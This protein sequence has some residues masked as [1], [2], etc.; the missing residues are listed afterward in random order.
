MADTSIIPAALA[1]PSG[2][3]TRELDAR[4]LE[5]SA[6]AGVTG[7]EDGVN[8]LQDVVFRLDV[9][10]RC[11]YI[12]PS[13]EQHSGLN[14]KNF[15]GKTVFEFGNGAQT[16]DAWGLAL[17]C[18]QALMSRRTVQREFCIRGRE[19]QTRLIP[20]MAEDGTV[21]SLLGISRDVTSLKRTERALKETQEQYRSL[22]ESIDGIV[23]EL[24]Y[25]TWRFTFVSRQ[26][27]RLLGYPV[28]RWL[29]EPTFW[30]DHVHAEDRDA[31]I[32]KCTR[33]SGRNENHELEYRM[34][35]ADGQIVWLR[36]IVTVEQ[37]EGRPFRLRGVMVDIT[38]VKN[39]EAERAGQNRI[40]EMIA[41]GAPLVEVLDEIVLLIESHC[42]GARCSVL[43]LEED[44]I[45]IG[46][47]V[48]AN[49]SEPLKSA[50]R[51]RKIGP[52]AGSCGT[53]MYLKRC[54][55]VQDTFTD[56]LWEDFRELAITQD[57]K[58]CWSTP[59]LTPQATVLGAFGMYYAESRAPNAAEQRLA[60]V[61]AR[62][63][64]IAIERD[65]AQESLRRSEAA[66][67]ESEERS[68]AT[69]RAIP[70]L[71]FLLSEEGT[72]LECHAQS[73]DQLVHERE[74]TIGTNIREALPGEIA[75]AYERAFR[76]ASKSDKAQTI[77]YDMVVRGERRH[78][79]TTIVRSGHGKFLAIVRNVSERKRA[80]AA[81]RESEE[82]FR[83]VAMA[84]RDAIYDVDLRRGIAW[85]NETYQ[86]L[87]S[88]DCPIPAEFGWWR[89]RIHPE[90]RERIVNEVHVAFLEGR[91]FWSDEYRFQRSNGTYANVMDRGYIFY[92]A[93][94]EVV[95]V[96]GA[97]TDVT[98][99]RE[100]E[101]ALRASEERYRN[102]VETQTELICRFLPDTTLTFVNDAYCRHFGKR[103]NELIGKSMLELVPEP[104]RTPLRQ[105]LFA[106][107]QGQ[108]VPPQESAMPQPDGTVR[109]TQWFNYALRDCEGKIELQGIARD[110]TE[111]KHAEQ[112]LRE[113]QE[114]LRRSHTQIR[115]LAG[116]LMNAQE[117][118]RR[119]LAREL[120][121][122]LN[123]QLAGLSILLSNTIR[124]LPSVEDYAAS[125]FVAYHLR[126]AMAAAR[127]IGD[128][129]RNLSHQLHPAT[130]EHAGISAAV[131]AI[132]K[133][134]ADA[135]P[136]DFQLI[137][138][139]GPIPLPDNVSICIYRIAQ[140]S[141]RNMVK[142]SGAHQAKVELGVHNRCLEFTVTDDGCGFDLDSARNKG[143]LGLISMFERIRLVQ[144][145]C[146]LKTFPGKGTSL[147]VTVPLR[148]E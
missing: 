122:D 102:V 140:E 131:R 8:E 19:Y 76:R 57:V 82:R 96:I 35:R 66:L 59:I 27:E 79:E 106:L 88:P 109:W 107:V 7:F 133:E 33:L 146:E 38:Q 54:V 37:C 95:R 60:E 70:D 78:R 24:D 86:R 124:E 148:S 75:D 42:A 9:D 56:P 118:E 26:A 100:S 111:Q 91:R 129:I 11:L 52:M 13:V 20:E 47:V 138:P 108:G 98:A 139:E 72:V 92:N 113:S 74:R 94:G 80:E 58:S 6:C 22:L 121:D 115:Q 63:A 4:Q 84:T 49:I 83:L 101:E 21:T 51:G 14:A 142:H 126:K 143:G 32:E 17:H 23:W 85:R 125:D 28:E 31:T 132:V 69:L 136:I 145:E 127:K 48:G 55:I 43:L 36:D 120:H 12:S 44:G 119:H 77:E 50:I 103:R 68:R 34:I 73:D 147:H 117:E 71:M 25:S 141:I 41:C 16:Y 30:P 29:N 62:L 10:L 61:A 134:F 93:T 53:A 87:Y 81:L 15:I 112:A 65:R 1:D 2:E 39:E 64:S 45:H 137:V 128:G 123:Q 135:Y 90:D 116:R 144:G 105:R 3:W 89:E 5:S 114:E 97:M 40:L 67:R 110:I 46:E 18:Q 130:L 104:D 99:Y